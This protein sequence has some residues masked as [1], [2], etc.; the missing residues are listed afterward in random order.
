MHR[1]AGRW[2]DKVSHECG[3]RAKF[4]GARYSSSCRPVFFNDIKRAGQCLWS[5][6]A[7]WGPMCADTKQHEQAVRISLAG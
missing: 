3:L 6:P 7:A 2:A 1:G 4:R 5:A